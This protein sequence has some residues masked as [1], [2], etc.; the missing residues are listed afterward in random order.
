MAGHSAILS[1]F[2]F[3]MVVMNVTS[4]MFPSAIDPFASASALADAAEESKIVIRSKRQQCICVAVL[5]QDSED[6][7]NMSPASNY[8]CAC[9]PTPTKS[10]MYTSPLRQQQDLQRELQIAKGIANQCG[11]QLIASRLSTTTTVSPVYSGNSVL[12][13]VY[14]CQCYPTATQSYIPP[15][16]TTT[17][18]TTQ[19]PTTTTS[20]TSKPQS[21]VIP[22]HIQQ[23]GQSVCQCFEIEVE[24]TQQRQFQCDCG[25]GATYYAAPGLLPTTTRQPVQ[26]TTTTTTTT[27]APITLPTFF[28][29]TTVP[30]VIATTK[31]APDAMPCVMVRIQT[32]EQACACQEN[33]RQCTE[34]VC[35]NVQKFRSLKTISP[36]PS[37]VD[38]LVDF[39][40]KVRQSFT[41]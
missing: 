27:P 21:I 39:L 37:T 13:P 30:P 20:V 17:T 32:G 22:L 1:L 3:S 31:E 28:N 36:P 5:F 12:Q 26:P 29:S 15:T 6:L 14:D 41:V 9:D 33:Y 38:L 18:T 16:T 4:E 24:L 11:C 25:N 19:A 2:A 10:G 8:Q 35:C 23:P 40:Q 34:N 7:Q